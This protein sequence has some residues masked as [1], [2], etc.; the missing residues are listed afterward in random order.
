MFLPT[1]KQVWDAVKISP[2][3]QVS[4]RSRVLFW[5]FCL[6]CGL[7]LVALIATFDLLSL[8][9]PTPSLCWV[10]RGGLNLTL[11]SDMPCVLFISG[12]NPPPT[13]RFYRIELG[14]TQILRWY[15]SLS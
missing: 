4:T 7:L 11:L 15:E 12:G 3:S 8:Q 14:P 6:N 1:A 10:L 5:N 2:F 9:P 13:S